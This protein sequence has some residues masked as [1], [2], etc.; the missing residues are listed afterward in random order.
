V[1]GAATASIVI[2]A[3]DE[4]QAI[5]ATLRSLLATAAAGEFEVIVV[6]NGCT[7]STAVRAGE[8]PGVEVVEISATS[9]IAALREGDHR[10]ETFPRIYLD[11]DTLLS[12][13]G[14]RALVTAL[15]GDGTRVAGLRADLDLRK[16]TRPGRWYYDFRCRL[17]VFAVGII[18]AGVYA[19]DEEGRR[20]LGEWPDVMGDDQFVLRSFA[21]RE[22]AVIEHHRTRTAAAPDL[23]AIVR[24]GV[25]VRRGNR[26]VSAGT[27]LPP[28]KSGL[29]T[30]LR[31]CA[32]Q[33][34]SWPGV[35]T[36]LGVTMLIRL[37]GR[38]DAGSGDWT[39][40]GGRQRR[41]ER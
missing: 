34:R 21:D 25:R 36:W 10:A 24:R 22:R 23:R 35:V 4:E 37:R 2:P 19:L 3:H 33:P 12:T 40:D 39:S 38:F 41:D 20:R 1:I 11:G 17:P 29:T 30:A 27:G 14:A 7:D 26:Q 13:D 32:T 31:R 6:C 8:V 15:S 18:G 16:T 9:K 5:A 28:P